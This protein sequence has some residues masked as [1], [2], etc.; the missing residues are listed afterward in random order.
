MNHNWK[1]L[2]IQFAY[3]CAVCAYTFVMTVLIAKTINYIPGLHLRADDEAETLGMDEDQVCTLL[4]YAPPS[5]FADHNFPMEI[6]LESSRQ[7]ISKFG[8]T[9][10]TGPHG[11][12]STP[13]PPS[14][15]TLVQ[16][17]ITSIRIRSR[18]VLGM[19]RRRWGV[20]WRVYGKTITRTITKRTRMGMGR[21][22]MGW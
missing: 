16:K 1:Q 21:M 10:Q 17:R 19:L 7:T 12:T 4:P 13:G 15:W 3:V 11:P 5:R 18:R 8:E 9:T 20:V 2:Y 22:E 6:R 14:L